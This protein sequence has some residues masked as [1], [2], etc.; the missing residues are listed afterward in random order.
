HIR[1]QERRP[2]GRGRTVRAGAAAGPLRLGRRHARANHGHRP[3]GARLTR[4]F[5]SKAPVVLASSRRTVLEEYME[6][7]MERRAAARHLDR[8]SSWVIVLTFVLFL[9]A[10]LVKGFKH[11]L[12]LETGVLLVSVK[13]ILNTYHMEEHTR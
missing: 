6:T 2:H 10:L 3:R 11:D 4:S 13:L 7:G 1:G 5:V 9:A 8:A 12:F